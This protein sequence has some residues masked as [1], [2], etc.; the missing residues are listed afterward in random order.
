MRLVLF[1]LLLSV[2]FLAKSCTDEENLIDFK[3]SYK[4]VSGYPL[5]ISGYGSGNRLLYSYAL[6]NNDSS[7]NCTVSSPSFLGASCGADSIVVRFD[8]GRGFICASRFNNSSNQCFLSDKSPIGG[9][10]QEEFYREIFP[11]TF[12][13]LITKEDFENAFEL[14]Q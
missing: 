9:T 11:N 10:G 8:S 13:F 12:E 5:L 2:L 1:T 7:P 14:P 3:S 6:E 4:N